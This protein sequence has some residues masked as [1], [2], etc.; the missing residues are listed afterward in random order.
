MSCLQFTTGAGHRLG[1]ARQARPMRPWHPPCRRQQK[2]P[3]CVAPSGNKGV[4]AGGSV[5][6]IF[7][8]LS[9]CATCAFGGLSA[10]QRRRRGVLWH[11]AGAAGGPAAR[12]LFGAP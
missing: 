4:G 2:E 5:D 12:V 8:F 10:Y 9:V 3:A 6:S 1:R 7:V 11:R